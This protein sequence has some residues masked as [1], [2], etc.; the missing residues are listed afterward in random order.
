MVNCG[1]SFGLCAIRVTTLADNGLPGGKYVVSHKP[2]EITY[3]P[4]IDTGQTFVSRSGCGCSVARFRADDVFNWFE[5][6]FSEDA[7]EPQ[8]EALMLGD[9]PILDSG[10]TVGVNG[11]GALACDVSPP[12]VGL[13]F[14]TQHIVGSGKDG[15]RP[16][17][18]WVYPATRWQRGNNSANESIARRVLNGFSRTNPMWGS[19]PYGDGPPDG[20]DVREFA[21]WQTNHALPAATDC[22][23]ATIAPGS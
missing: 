23:S 16:Y 12:Y 6:S 18:H 13:E 19:G 21:W 2:V 5:F 8:I 10:D 20:Q 1:V 22:T 17:I 7:L 4:N 15:I 9:T 14:W 3:N 11:V